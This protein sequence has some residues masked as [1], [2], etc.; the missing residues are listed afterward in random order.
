MSSISVR[1]PE[2]LLRELDTRARSI[3]LPRTAYIR[4]AI[5]HLNKEM[6]NQES[7]KRL[8]KASLKVRNESM[9]INKEFDD[10]EH[11]P[12]D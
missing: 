2:K 7:R 9:R 3:H 6:Q 11:D 8:M 5:E 12:E 4:L 1:L 10:I